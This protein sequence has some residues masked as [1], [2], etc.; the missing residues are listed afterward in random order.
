MSKV[1]QEKEAIYN[2]GDQ[3]VIKSGGPAMTIEKAIKDSPFGSFT[4]KYKCQWFAG[5]KLDTGTFPEE[6]LEPYTPK[7]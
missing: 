5:K 6:S 4:G 2:I 3:V 7:P 1:P